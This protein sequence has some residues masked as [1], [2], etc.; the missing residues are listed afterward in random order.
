MSHLQLQPRRAFQAARILASDPDDLPQVFTI[1]ESL[2]ADTLQRTTSRMKRSAAGQRL[3]ATRPDIVALLA[4][5]AALAKLPAGS[6]GRT[7]LAFVERENISPA[8]IRAAAKK[9]MTHDREL[10][11]PLDFVHARMRDTHDLWHAVTGYSGDVLGEA[12]LLAF[13]FSQTWNPG[14][15]FIL[16]IAMTKTIRSKIG[17]GPAARR[18]IL[19]G[20]RRGQKAAWLPAQEWESMLALP[21]EEVRLRLNV[22][23]LP[24]YREV[25]S[26]EIKAAA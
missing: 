17:D 25:R 9:G 14:I 16:G 4:D 11:A 18:M 2:S 7:Y 24:A 26:A 13:I 20:F 5:R 12:S 3:L 22:D 1:I 10:P 21:I 8:G 6:L 23:A 15:A 19:D